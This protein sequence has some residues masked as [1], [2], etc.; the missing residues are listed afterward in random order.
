MTLQLPRKVLQKHEGKWVAWDTDTG[1]FLAAAKTFDAL[2]KKVKPVKRGRVIGYERVI[3]RDA[4]I[5]GGLE[6]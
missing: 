6:L 3:P 5:V 4:V 2:A 1:E